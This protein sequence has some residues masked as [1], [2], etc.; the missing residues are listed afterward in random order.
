MAA[1]DRAVGSRD[2]AEGRRAFAEN[3]RPKF[4]GK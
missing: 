2:N 4:T 3:R 1:I